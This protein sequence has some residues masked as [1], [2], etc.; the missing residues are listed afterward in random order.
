[1][2]K[3]VF[4]G[5][6]KV[7]GNS[8]MFLAVLRG[9]IYLLTSVICANFCSCNDVFCWLIRLKSRCYY[10]WIFFLLVYVLVRKQLYCPGKLSRCIFALNNDCAFPLQLGNLQ[11]CVH[12]QSCHFIDSN[13]FCER[14]GKIYGKL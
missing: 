14:H 5:N 4:C 11:V 9:F 7:V 8:R 2:I 12:C 10:F 13:F 1:M 3:V 6:F